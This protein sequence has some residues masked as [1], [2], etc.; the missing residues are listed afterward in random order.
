MLIR[1]TVHARTG[2]PLVSEYVP[3]TDNMAEVIGNL[4]S[5]LANLGV[6][7]KLDVEVIKG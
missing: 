4:V 3:Y 1:V 7:Y 6:E 5:S 2:E